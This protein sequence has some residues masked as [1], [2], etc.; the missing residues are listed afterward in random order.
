MQILIDS[1]MWNEQTCICEGVTWKAGVEALLWRRELGGMA[2][3][4]FGCSLMMDRPSARLAL[5]AR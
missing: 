3:E 2:L 4:A 5:T 1:V